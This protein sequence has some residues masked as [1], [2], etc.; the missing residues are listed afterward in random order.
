[1]KARDA[2][3]DHAGNLRDGEIAFGRQQPFAARAD[4]LAT[5]IELT[6]HARAYVGL[7]VVEMLLELVF[8]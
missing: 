8:H 1:M 5:F 2:S 3:G 6:D 4:P 7:P